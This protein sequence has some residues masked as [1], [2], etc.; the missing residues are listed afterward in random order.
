LLYPSKKHDF[1]VVKENAKTSIIIARFGKDLGI[2]LKNSLKPSTPKV[3]ANELKETTRLKQTHAYKVDLAKIDGK[4][5]FPCPRCGGT[6]SPDDCSEEAYS[7]RG[8]K[9]NKQGLEEVVIRC[10]MCG[11][12]LHLTGF[13]LL[14]NTIRE[15]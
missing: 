3:Q 1:Y 4:G 15:K 9:V 2:N 13:S 10:N 11:S 5:A 8:T 12:Q 6:I 7:I 14:Q